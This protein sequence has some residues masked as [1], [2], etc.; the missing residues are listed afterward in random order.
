MEAGDIL[1][2]L[3]K[4]VQ[5]GWCRVRRKRDSNEGLVPFALIL[6]PVSPEGSLPKEGMNLVS[7]MKWKDI[8][9]SR[10]GCMVNPLAAKVVLYF[11][12]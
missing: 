2:I 7:T 11:L 4:D 3:E 12:V 8:L 10:F 5:D 6:Q 1:F 9:T